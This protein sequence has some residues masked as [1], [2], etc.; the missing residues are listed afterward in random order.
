M[1]KAKQKINVIAAADS[2]AGPAKDVR[3]ERG[4][5]RLTEIHGDYGK[6]V[7][8]S[9]DTIAP[10]LKNWVI[11]FAFGEVYTRPGLDLRCRQL[12]TLAALVVQGNGGA[13]LEAHIRGT[14]NV[15]V[16]R[17][18]IIEAIMQLAV[19]AGFPAA[20]HGVITAGEVFAELDGAGTSG[21]LPGWRDLRDKALKRNK[22]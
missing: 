21:A 2:G 7:L 22:R 15:G 13:E 6:Q 3:F 4:L 9:L 17:G 11:S 16:S 19:Y 5:A 1:P 8:A 20:I 18:E 14:L 12:V 10:D